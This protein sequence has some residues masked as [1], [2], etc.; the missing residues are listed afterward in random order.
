M[1]KAELIGDIDAA[2]DNE[3]GN[4]E[5][6]HLSV[7]PLFHRMNMAIRVFKRT[8]CNQNSVIWTT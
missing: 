3:S 5:T 7:H 2:T 8:L 1:I 4:Q 6:D